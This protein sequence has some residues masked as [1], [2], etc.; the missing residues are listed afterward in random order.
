MVL[1]GM[2]LLGLSIFSQSRKEVIISS[3]NGYFSN[4][5][6]SYTTET[7]RCRIE[8]VEVDAS[9]RTL[10]VYLNEMFAGQS[11]TKG[12][13]EGIYREVKRLLPAP[14]NAYNIIILGN[15][16]PIEHLITGAEG[17][18]PDAR[19]TWGKALYHGAPWVERVQRPYSITQ[20]MQKRHL[21]V[22]ASHGRYYKN[23][24]KEWT[25]QRPYLYCTTEDL[26]TQT[27]V[28]PFL[29]PML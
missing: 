22:W 3:L 8:S 25:W 6:T 4:Y 15:G 7:D 5:Q 27:I 10:K 9:T 23:D 14:Y 12:K 19:K 11:F 17:V 26:F 1:A 2:F 20:G 24:K 16:T 18:L 29:I 21:A 28:S 13:V